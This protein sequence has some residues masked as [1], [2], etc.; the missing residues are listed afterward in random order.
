[1]VEVVVWKNMDGFLPWYIRGITMPLLFWGKLDAQYN[2][3]TVS[4]DE[5]IEIHS[6][7]KKILQNWYH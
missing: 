3:G 2:D 7:K 5:W 6:I 1:V 4:I